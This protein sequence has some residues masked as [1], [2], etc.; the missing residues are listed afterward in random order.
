MA[1]SALQG[2]TRLQLEQV[3]Q[4]LLGQLLGQH[5]GRRAGRDEG[6]APHGDQPLGVARREA[7]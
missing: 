3:R 6:A 1:I 5:L 2:S 7:A 4:Q